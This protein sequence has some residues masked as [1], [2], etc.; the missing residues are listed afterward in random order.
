MR[1]SWE[2]F[3]G[4][5]IGFGFGYMAGI[6]KAEDYCDLWAREQTRI[7]VTT[8]TDFTTLTSTQLMI[9]QYK[10]KNLLICRSMEMKPMLEGSSSDEAWSLDM[11]QILIQKAQT[12]VE[13]QGTEPAS[14]S[15]KEGEDWENQCR[16]NYRSFDPSD[17]TV[18]RRGNSERVRC[19]CGDTIDCR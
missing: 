3:V 17:G 5:L 10:A 11:Y 19:P 8:A 16:A 6:A 18:V 13:A 1:W 9:Q 12:A 2:G 7:D 15:P 4:A 14:D